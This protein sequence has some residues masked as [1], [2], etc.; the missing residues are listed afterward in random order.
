MRHQGVHA[1]PSLDDKTRYVLSLF[2]W[3]FSDLILDNT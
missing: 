2:Q 3:G 1:I